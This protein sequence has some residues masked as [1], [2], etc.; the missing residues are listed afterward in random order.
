[1]AAATSD[2]SVLTQ[3]VATK[4]RKYADVHSSPVA[5][6]LVVGCETYGRWTEDA[7]RI[8]RELAALKAREAPPLLQ[9]CAR[10]SW[11]NRWWALVSVGVQRA[12]AE[13]LLCGGGPDL[14]AYPAVTS[15]PPLADL[16]AQF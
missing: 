11:S 9:G 4:R 12:I 7:I 1:M 8:M 14:Q 16:V 10:Y 3:A 15:A 6:L 13:A 2:G 5:C